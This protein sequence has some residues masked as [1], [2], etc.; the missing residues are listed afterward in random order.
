MNIKFNE[1]FYNAVDWVKTH[2]WDFYRQFTPEVWRCA[3][4]YVHKRAH[5]KKVK[6]I[7]RSLKNYSFERLKRYLRGVG[8]QEYEN[9]KTIYNVNSIERYL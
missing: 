8:Y 9:G 4:Y 5:N 6:D 3:Q 2:N 1:D 7:R